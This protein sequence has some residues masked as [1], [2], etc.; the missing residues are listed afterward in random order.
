MTESLTGRTHRDDRPKL[1]NIPVRS[2]QG[3][4]LRE[5]IRKALYGEEGPKTTADWSE[6]ELRVAEH[7]SRIRRRAE[8]GREG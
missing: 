2:E 7:M 1:Q 5:I 4:Q 6:A 3:S 8:E